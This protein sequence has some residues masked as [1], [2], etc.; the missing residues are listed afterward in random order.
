LGRD[1]KASLKRWILLFTLFLLW[2]F[3]DV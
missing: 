1:W 3:C 2:H